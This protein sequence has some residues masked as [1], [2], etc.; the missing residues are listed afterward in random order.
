MGAVSVR[1]RPIPI[2]LLPC[3]STL[4]VWKMDSLDLRRDRLFQRVAQH[5]PS[6]ETIQQGQGI[7]H[8]TMLPFGS[9]SVFA[10]PVIEY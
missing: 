1:V 4:S 2:R 7:H 10:I 6:P 3:R 5:H 8:R 9:L